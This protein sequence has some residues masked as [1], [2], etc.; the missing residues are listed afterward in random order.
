ML[1]LAGPMST[2]MQLLLGLVA[3]IV[4]L[5][6][7]L[8]ALALAWGMSWSALTGYVSALFYGIKIGQVTISLGDIL[9]AIVVLGVGIWLTR[10]FSN[11]LNTRLERQAG[12]DPG[13]RNSAVTGLTY[14]GYLL[15]GVVAIGA[16]GLDLSNLALIAGALSV[17]IGFGLQNIVNNFVSGLIVLFERPIKVGD[18]VEIDNIIGKVERVGI[19][20]SVIRSTAGA[21][22]IIP[23]G[24]LISDRV[25]NWTLPGRLHQLT[26]PVVTKADVDAGDTKGLLLEIANANQMVVENPPPEA[27]FTKRN[28]DT[29][30][31][32]LRAWTAALDQWLVVRS[33]LTTEINAALRAREIKAAQDVEAAKGGTLSPP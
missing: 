26:V 29:F 19:R 15:A 17:G 1:G 10:F 32:E 18:T 31:F 11:G 28:L 30:E 13:V 4:L 3:D 20:A 14:I 27:L 12:V 22:V 2:T 6:L 21:E 24:K 33:D 25:T 5:V 9:A 8:A 16:V 23:N 7:L